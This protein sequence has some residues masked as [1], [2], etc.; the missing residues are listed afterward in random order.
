MAYIFGRKA[1][2][3]ISTFP[4]TF[5]TS[6][7]WACPVAMEAYVFVIG[8]G[9]GG[10]AGEAD[11]NVRVQGGCA[12]GCAV[13]KLSLKAQNYAIVV[14]SGGASKDPGSAY[15]DGNDG[16]A[17]T[18]FDNSGGTAI[19]QM[20]GNAGPGGN[21]A[22]SGGSTVAAQTGGTATGGNLM[23]NTGG[24]VPAVDTDGRVTGGGAVGL[25]GPGED[26]KISSGTTNYAGEGGLVWG[27]ET[28]GFGMDVGGQSGTVHWFAPPFN[29]QTAYR[30]VGARPNS[31]SDEHR[32]REALP[33]G[34]PWSSWGNSSGTY[35]R[36]TTTGTPFSGSGGFHSNAQYLYGGGTALGGGGGGFITSHGS[37][38]T[39][40]PGGGHGGV[41]IIPISMGS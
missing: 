6:Q 10:A 33:A 38:V 36:Y 12:G 19:T 16:S 17:A 7:T 3:A 8:P 15:S 26:G 11:G 28:G 4:I 9:G 27:P 21:S 37:G 29:V 41:I 22:A 30:A 5:A 13:S 23:N 14:G 40:G 20:V 1:S 31:N 2:G 32:R 34:T 39:W 18:T 24:G 25:W 35:T